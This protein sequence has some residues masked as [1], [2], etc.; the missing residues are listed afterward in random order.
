MTSLLRALVFGPLISK[1]GIPKMGLL[2]VRPESEDLASV[3]E[4]AAEGEL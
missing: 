1:R 3:T 2:E 4:L